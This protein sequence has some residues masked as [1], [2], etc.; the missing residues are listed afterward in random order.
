MRQQFTALFLTFSLLV[1]YVSDSALSPELQAPSAVTT[2]VDF[3]TPPKYS[4]WIQSIVKV[5]DGDTISVIVYL[6]FDVSHKVTVRLENI[7]TPEIF[8]PVSELERQAGY[9]MKEY[10]QSLVS[11]YSE[12]LFLETH[13]HRELYSRYLGTLYFLD[14]QTGTPVSI[15]G[16]LL[17]YMFENHLTKLEVQH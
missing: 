11:Q 8:H 5:V 15:N 17:K 10:F 3:V 16:L 7:D 12:S 1:P 6:G 14:P 2:A 13:D 9:K 4:Y